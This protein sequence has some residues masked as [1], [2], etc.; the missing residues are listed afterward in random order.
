LRRKEQR[1]RSHPGQ[2]KAP[3]ERQFS[4][5]GVSQL[6]GVGTRAPTDLDNV[7]TRLTSR[8]GTSSEIKITS[9]RYAD[10]LM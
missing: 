5:Q 2:G 8:S 3:R 7:W 4:F 6:N 9:I 1:D 10:K